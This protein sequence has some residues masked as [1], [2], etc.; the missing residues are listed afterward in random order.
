MYKTAEGKGENKYGKDVPTAAAAS[1]VLM[2]THT[3][4]QNL[5]C[6]TLPL[7]LLAP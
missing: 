6:L 4:W 3:H 7:T 5:R 2:E 1:A